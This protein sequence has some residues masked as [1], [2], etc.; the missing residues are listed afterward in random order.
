MSE[1][2][3]RQIFRNSADLTYRRGGEDI[4]KKY[5]A[6]TEDRFIETILYIKQESEPQTFTEKIIPIIPN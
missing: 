1:K 3:L 2:E 5:K 6:M 4:T